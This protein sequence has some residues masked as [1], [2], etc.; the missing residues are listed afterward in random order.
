[1][2]FFYDDLHEVIRTL[3]EKIVI[4][5]VL[6][7]SKTASSLY[8]IDFTKRDIFKEK[9][10]IGFGAT[11]EINDSLTKDLVTNESTKS[12]KKDCITFISAMR[13]K[14][15][16]R[17]PLKYAV[18]QNSSSISPLLIATKPNRT[19]TYFKNFLERMV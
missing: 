10:D 14:L 2:P 11:V 6:N 12:F 19:K 9:P 7:E 16:E 1:M 13:T 17:S 5:S 15:L 18:I 8:K 4:S 3:M